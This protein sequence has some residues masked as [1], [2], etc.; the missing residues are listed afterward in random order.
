MPDTLG[1]RKH[2]RSRDDRSL[3]ATHDV[4]HDRIER[5]AGED[6]G[7]QGIDP[8][9]CVQEPGGQPRQY[10]TCSPDKR[11]GCWRRPSDEC[12]CRDSRS[13]AEGTLGGEIDLSEDAEADEHDERRQREQQP[14]G[15]RA[16]EQGHRVDTVMVSSRLPHARPRANRLSRWP[17]S[18]LSGSR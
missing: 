7:Q 12:R 17:L 18:R 11:R 2:G 15:E 6:P 1:A 8:Q 14:H 16:D 9:P 10:A 3:A 13:D 4:E 5:G